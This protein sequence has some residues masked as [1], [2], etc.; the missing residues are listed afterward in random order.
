MVFNL[1]SSDLLN[2]IGAVLMLM[3]MAAIIIG[4]NV[5]EDERHND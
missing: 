3:A 5:V 2:S 1:F 4:I